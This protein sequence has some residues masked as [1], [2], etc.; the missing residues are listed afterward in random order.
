MRAAPRA[1]V[2]GTGNPPSNP[3]KP[4]SNPGMPPSNPGSPPSNPGP[5][6]TQ[7][8]RLHVSPCGQSPSAQSC[9]PVQDAP[10]VQTAS[11]V[12][13]RALRQ[14]IS[15]SWQ[16]DVLRQSTA[17]PVQPAAVVQ[18]GRR[19]TSAVAADLTGR[20]AGR[21]PARDCPD[22]SGIGRSRVAG[23]RGVCPAVSDS[24]VRGA[25][26]PIRGRARVSGVALGRG[27]CVSG[28]LGARVVAGAAGFSVATDRPVVAG[29]PV[30]TGCAVIANRC[31]AA[32]CL[33]GRGLLSR[34]V[35]RPEAAVEDRHAGRRT[36]ATAGR[37]GDR[38]RREG[39]RAE[40][41]ATA[42]H[43]P[44]SKHIKTS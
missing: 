13:A 31:V 4:P 41:R 34:A 19:R 10:A 32:A 36:V 38:K 33:A 23:R 42:P 11:T 1:S 17:V 2:Y 16:F 21:R 6:P 25:R 39:R 12:R 22:A 30:V 35:V 28:V 44:E 8:P 40:H 26:A 14:H 43:Q 24:G 37:D 27:P 9:T 15:P 7:K 18:V 3:K 29:C 20:R 5:V